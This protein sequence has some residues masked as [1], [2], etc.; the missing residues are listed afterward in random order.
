M[1]TAEIVVRP[2]SPVFGAEVL[3]IDLRKDLSDA[4]REVLRSVWHRHALLLFRDQKL[5]PEQQMEVATIFGKVSLQGEN[6]AKGGGFNYVSNVAKDGANPN[7]ELTFHTDHSFYPSPLRGIM[8]YAI[9]V[10][11]AGAGGDTLF[12]SAKL[13]YGLLPERL[14]TKIAELEALHVYDYAFG[15]E[16]YGDRIR[17]KDLNPNSPRALHPLAMVH[18]ETGDNLLYVSRRH[19]DRIEGLPPDE[20]EALIDELLTYIYRPE[21]VFRHQWSPG[22]LV[23]FDNLALQHARN[24]FD[25]KYKR[26]LRRI[27]IA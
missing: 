7:G 14:R 22:D 17:E 20:S 27:Q 11:P 12:A 8:L 2:L 21:I 18:P 19:V 16:R 15:R 13:A 10:P 24:D 9:E 23:I 4:T 3:G 26:H 1:E 5:T 25:P 6:A